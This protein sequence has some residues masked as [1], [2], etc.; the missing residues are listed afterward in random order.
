MKT[1]N[2]ILIAKIISFFLKPFYKKNQIHIRDGIK[3]HLDLNEGIDL[4]IFLFG[5]S[6]K[7]IKNLKYLFKSDSGLTIIDIGANIGSISLPLA[8]I[9]NKSKIFA[10]EPTNYAFKKLNKNLNLNKHLK[11]NIFLNQLFLSKIKRPK[12]VWSS[13]NFTSNKNKHKQHLGIL[14]SIKKK[15]YITLTKFINLKKIKKVDFIKLDVD[16]HELDI[17][18]SGEKFLKKKTPVIFIEIAPYLYPEFGYECSELITYIKKLKYSFYSEDLKKISNIDNY[19]KNITYGG[20]ENF[21]LMK[22]YKT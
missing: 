8:K 5:T 18:K 6:E 2:K 10:I 14:H 22:N 20:S 7:K 13:W 3:W 21:Y 1:K 16:G 11:K 4:S 17:L 19:I 15:S 12:K 9:F